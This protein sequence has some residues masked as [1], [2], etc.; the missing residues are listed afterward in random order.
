MGRLAAIFERLGEISRPVPVEQAAWALAS[1]EDVGAELCLTHDLLERIVSHLA[2][3]D[4][5]ALSC[6]CTLLRPLSAS[7][8]PGIA[9]T[10]YPHQKASLHFMMT[11]EASDWR[12]GILADEPGTGKTVTVL[13]LLGKTAGL[14]TRPLADLERSRIDAAD[15]VWASLAL[16]Y[17]R[18]LVYAILKDLRSRCGRGYALFASSGREAAAKLEGYPTLVPSP[19]DDYETLRADRA[20]GRFPTRSAFD[21]AVRAVPRAASTYWSS[22][23]AARSHPA[24]APA[25]AEI[26]HA[27]TRLAEAVEAT[28]D[29]H[30]PRPEGPPP[31]L[32]SRATLLVVP[33]PL[34]QHWKE[35]IE[36]H[37]QRHA[38]QGAV[39]VDAVAEGKGDK[40]ARA[41]TLGDQYSASELAAASV[42]ITSAE[43]LSMEQ[44]HASA[45]GEQSLLC[46]V[47]WVR[48]VCDEGQFL[49][50]GALTHCKV[51]LH[52]IPAE[53]RWVLS[54]TPARGTSDRDG[55]S[56]LG[57]LLS[58]L[59]HP[60]GREWAGVARRFLRQT[61]GAEA[62]S[63]EDELFH[64]LA[65][66]MVRQLKSKIQVPKPIRSTIL[67][68]CSV[69]E[70]LAYNSLVSYI[71][72]NL[73][74]TGLQG[75]SDG[76]G[77]DV[78]L[79]HHS[80]LRSARKAIDNLRLASNGGGKQVATLLPA[81]FRE[82]RGWLIERYGAPEHAVRRATHFMESAQRGQALPCDRC[83]LPLLMLLV[84]PLCGH[85]C[86]PECLQS[87]AVAATAVA[88]SVACSTRGTATDPHSATDEP[89][90]AAS[91]R[92]CG[93]PVCLTPLPEVQYLKCPRCDDVECEHVHETRVP[94]TAHPIDA[95]AY[96]QPGFDLQW[97][98]TLQEA[99]ARALAEWYERQRREERQPPASRSVVPRPRAVFADFTVGSGGSS[100]STGGGGGSGSS[101]SS[102]ADAAASTVGQLSSALVPTGGGHMPL[103]HTKAAHIIGAIAA[104]RLEERRAT[105][106]TQLGRP[107]TSESFDGRPVR[108]AVYSESRRTLDQLGHFLY[109]RFGDD[110][111][112]QFWGQYRDTELRKFRTGHVQFWRCQR[113]P[114]RHDT[115][116]AAG[117]AAAAGGAGGREVEFPELRCYGKHLTLEVATEHA[118]PGIAAAAPFR[119]VVNEED[120]RLPGEA[121]FVQGTQWTVGQ[122]VE[123]RVPSVTHATL[124]P[125]V[126]ARIRSFSKC[127]GRMGEQAWCT[128]KVDCFVLL[129]TRD[130]RVGLDLSMLTHLYLADQCWDPAVEAQVISRAFRMG[131][132]GPCRIE[133][134]LMR[135]TLEHALHR[136]TR[137]GE[138][139]AAAL[140]GAAPLA[141][142][143]EATRKRAEELGRESHA[144]GYTDALASAKADAKAAATADAM[145][146][147]DADAE[148]TP[149]ATSGSGGRGAAA[150]AADTC[151]AVD[152]EPSMA[153]S[154]K[155][156]GKRRVSDGLPPAAAKRIC[157][158]DALASD[159]TPTPGDVE[160]DQHGGGAGRGVPNHDG[161]AS[162]VS[163]ASAASS[164][165]LLP[166]APLGE[167]AKVHGLLRAMTFL[168]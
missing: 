47:N 50:G 20:I 21:A 143:D 104:L 28:L 18:E 146:D 110:A 159:G 35:Q 165:L 132:T 15:Q 107:F 136:A 116:T 144:G 103:Q 119:L 27:A 48:L 149:S 22:A 150:S 51:L 102:D 82:C 100:S 16:P 10:L 11:S 36:W 117:A 115:M 57:G 112:A 30:R 52:A 168:R 77:A 63:A 7:T 94:A 167:E 164:H 166:L 72:A 160:V 80:N 6:T 5:A 156:L 31:P 120:V 59:R 121:A 39:L 89:T 99:E 25:A 41:S 49:G 71:Q 129:L 137:G 152:G 139:D 56:T 55:C 97:Q 118:A 90:A 157:F 93:C 38:L 106:A 124:G 92:L 37:V 45:T 9:L 4:V 134:L 19:P 26:A 12:G 88:S 81:Y 33:R 68:E 141:E 135:G 158:E 113:C 75:A 17:K 32:R 163:A 83:G 101:Y 43:R 154:S 151:A 122:L 142:A 53:R 127:G 105:E 13:A 147:L 69:A 67:L 131:A 91:R 128:R 73:V 145:A 74:L 126:P 40:R 60:R 130:G 78:S 14:Q 34:L 24:G 108:V 46:G 3:Q 23:V 29:A 76:A 54:G 1:T 65:P 95:F 133:Q 70:Q 85:L 86:C 58:F 8:Y 98:E 61:T 64:F 2:A 66:L 155:A 140:V 79:L 148:E 44:R 87:E 62:A 162:A 123:T 109:L 96:L 42:V 138:A 114:T 153:L 84:M 111:I 161:M 125:W